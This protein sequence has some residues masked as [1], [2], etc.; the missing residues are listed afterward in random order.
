M[1][2]D[3]VERL[4]I[5]LDVQQLFTQTKPTKRFLEHIEVIPNDAIRALHIHHKHRANDDRPDTLGRGVHAAGSVAGRPDQPGDPPPERN[6]GGEGVLLPAMARQSRKLRTNRLTPPPSCVQ[7]R[8]F[9]S[10]IGAKPD[11]RWSTNL[12]LA[13]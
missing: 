3:F 9:W 1:G 8:N 11:F 7:I 6:R 10:S 13:S 4:G 12:L 2:A 5:V